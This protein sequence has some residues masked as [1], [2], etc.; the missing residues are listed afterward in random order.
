MKKT[1]TMVDHVP[2]VLSNNLAT[3]GWKVPVAIINEESEVC[4]LCLTHIFHML[5]VFA[6]RDLSVC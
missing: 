6:D 4:D 3:C 5:A 1:R 2:S